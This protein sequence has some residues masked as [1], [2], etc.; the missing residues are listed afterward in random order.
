MSPGRRPLLLLVLAPLN[1]AGNIGA[2]AFFAASAHASRPD[3]FVLWQ[4]V[5]GFFGLATNITFAG[6]VRYWSLAAANI[7]AV[8]VVFVAVQVF[9]AYA[10]FH[11]PFAWWQ[12]LGSA[13]VFVGLVLVATRPDGSR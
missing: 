10:L 1:I 13:C 7:I 2:L 3:L 8:G 6:L 5:G 11:S 12:W 4:I 9:V